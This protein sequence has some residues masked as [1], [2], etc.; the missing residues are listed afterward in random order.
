M[1]GLNLGRGYRPSRSDFS[2]FFSKTRSEIRAMIPSK[3]PTEGTPPIRPCLTSGQLVLIL[4]F[5]PTLLLNNY[6]I[7]TL[8]IFTYEIK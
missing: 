7:D 3:D 8:F 5:N 6:L 4:E 2:V 1:P